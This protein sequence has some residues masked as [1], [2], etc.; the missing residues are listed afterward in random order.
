MKARRRLDKLSAQLRRSLNFFRL[1]DGSRRP[2]STT[3]LLDTFLELMDL[4][5]EKM[6]G[7]HGPAAQHAALWPVILQTVALPGSG[8]LLGMMQGMLTRQQARR[9]LP[10]QAA[11]E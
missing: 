6:Q 9:R 4:E 1:P 2:I 3:Q 7:G 11:E 10:A 5:A 8:Q